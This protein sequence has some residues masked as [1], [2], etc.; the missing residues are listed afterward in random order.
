MSGLSMNKEEIEIIIKNLG[1]PYQ[2]L[3]SKNILNSS[4]LVCLY[5]DTDTLEFELTKSIE[6]IFWTESLKLEMIIFKINSA[7]PVLE[8]KAQSCLPGQL[9]F[10]KSQSDVHRELGAPIF[11]KTPMELYG[12]EFYGWDT[13]QL[14]K[15]LHPEALIDIQYDKSF[16]IRNIMISLIDKHV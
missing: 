2:L 6:L 3:V 1:S 8:F 15:N 5:E 13:F 11:F 16:L 10:L 4:E 9:S 12:T 14:D 7:L